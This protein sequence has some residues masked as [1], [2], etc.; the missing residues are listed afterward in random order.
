[1]FARQPAGNNAASGDFLYYSINM[2][3]TPPR[4][5]DVLAAPPRVVL[6]NYYPF[7]AGEVSSTFWCESSFFFLVVR[8]HGSVRIGPKLFTLSSGQAVHVP[9]SSPIRFTADRR[10][11][12]TILSVHLTYA[13]WPNASPGPP[14]LHTQD[15]DLAR[16]TYQAPPHPQLYTDAFLV[17]TPL[18]SPLAEIAT[19]IAHTYEAGMTG[20]PV[21]LR[22][23]R[24]RGLALTF[25]AEFKQCMQAGTHEI[26][27]QANAA[28]V[29]LVREVAS[30]MQLSLA[31]A[32]KARR[33]SYADRAGISEA[34]L[35]RAFRAVTGRSPIDYLIELRLSHARRALRTS[36]ATVGE[37]AAQVGIPDIYHFSKLFKKRVGCSPLQYRARLKL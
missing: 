34:T 23:A 1:M 37:I 28:Q 29:R 19:D 6:A 20:A 18:D 7:S 21:E 13:P 12:F 8:G 15:I 36:R 10:D 9:W 16:E 4:E 35:A 2:P 22:E 31:G 27:S 26:Q 5:F 25:V 33:T 32:V 14:R 17:N 30:Y 11:P 3:R 24:L